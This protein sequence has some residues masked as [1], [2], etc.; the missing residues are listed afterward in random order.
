[1]GFFIEP[2]MIRITVALFG[3]VGVWYVGWRVPTR[4]QVLSEVSPEET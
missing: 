4:E 1:V 2:L 3:L